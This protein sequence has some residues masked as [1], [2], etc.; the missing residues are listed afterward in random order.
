[1][2][3]NAHPFILENPFKF[4][5]QKTSL[6]GR[7]G[8]CAEDVFCFVFFTRIPRPIHLKDGLQTA[9]DSMRFQ[10]RAPKS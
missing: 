6:K 3:K 8:V 5:Y 9:S 1:M 10:I 2:G 7:I 4:F